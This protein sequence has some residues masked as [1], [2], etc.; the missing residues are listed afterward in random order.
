MATDTQTGSARQWKAGKPQTRTSRT[1]LRG[2]VMNALVEGRSQ[3][4]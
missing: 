1:V 2:A 4:K 3:Q